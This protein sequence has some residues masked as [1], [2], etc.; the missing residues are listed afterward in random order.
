MRRTPEKFRFTAKVPRVISHEKGLV[1][2]IA[3]MEEFLYAMEPLGERL[4][5]LLLQ[6]PDVARGRMRM[7]TSTAVS[8]SIAWRNFCR[9]CPRRIFA[10]RWR[11]ATGDGCGKRW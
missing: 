5:P 6:F 4:G 3:E 7:R 11:C 10:L 2:C 1:D 9:N 8:F